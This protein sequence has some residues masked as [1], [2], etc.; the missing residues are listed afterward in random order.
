MTSNFEL[1]STDDQ[2]RAG[3][4][5]TRRGRIETPFFMSVA[6]RAAIKAG[7]GMEDLEKIKA[8]VVLANT[9]HL[10]LKPGADLILSLIHI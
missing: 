3:V 5:H 6:T 9:Y 7:V 1:Q 2:A 10:H 8:P 4:L